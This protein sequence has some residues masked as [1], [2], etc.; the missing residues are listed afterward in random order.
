MIV[1]KYMA[2]VIKNGEV[3]EA[4]KDYVLAE[5]Q[6]IYILAKTPITLDQA[7]NKLKNNH[8]INS[9]FEGRENFYW[10]E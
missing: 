10:I 5:I 7:Y 1:E 4:H 2:E 8:N 3:F 6:S 9:P